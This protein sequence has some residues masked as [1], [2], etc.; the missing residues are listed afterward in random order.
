[1]SAH[2]ADPP[3]PVKPDVIGVGFL[4]HGVP[5]FARLYE[6]LVEV[7]GHIDLVEFLAAHHH[8]DP[9]HLADIIDSL[10]G[11]PSTLHCFEYMI[12]SVDRPAAAT[13]ERLRRMVELSNCRYIGEHVGVMGT[14]DRYSGTFLQP[15][16]TDEQTEV[17]IE[18]LKRDRDVAGVPF[19]IENQAQIYDQVGPRSVCEQ[20]R[21]IA[22]GADV[23]ILLSMSN[24]TVAERFHPMD[25]ER[26]LEAIPLERVWQLHI[27]LGSGAELAEPDNGRQR[28]EQEWAHAT[29]E[30]LFK[31]ESFRPVSIVLEVQNA[32]TIALAT[33]EEIRDGLDWARD[34]LGSGADR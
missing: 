8:A 30:Q 3:V 13:V 16:G 12:G 18:N 21:D 14:R 11:V 19:I 29:A 4:Y 10:G 27:P 5:E 26:E 31:E 32:G 22:E 7:G 2:V 23:G 25:R 28:R 6:R 1:M 34:L 9:G 17:F 33:P 24:F 20:V 15:F